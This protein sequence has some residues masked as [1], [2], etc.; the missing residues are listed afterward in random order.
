M[1]KKACESPRREPRPRPTHC[2][3]ET[4]PA[5]GTGLRA[6]GPICDGEELDYALSPEGLHEAL[7][8][9]QRGTM[10]KASVSAWSLDGW[11]RCVRLS[12]SLLDGTY[13]PAPPRHFTVTN[14]K[15]RE[16]VSIG[17]RDRVYQRSL[18][19][20]AVYPVMTR[21]LVRE[22]CACQEGKGTDFARDLLERDIRRWWLHHGLDG[23]VM[24]LDIHGYYDHLRHDVALGPFRRRLGP[25]TY[26]RVEE[27][28]TTQ[29]AGD[30]GF[31]P[32]SQL[33][34]LVGICTLDPLDH[35][36]KEG[37]G[38]RDYVRYMDDMVLLGDRRQLEAWRA[39]VSRW[40]GER[41]LE[42]NE[43]KTRFMPLGQRIPFLGLTFQLTE[44]GRVIRRMRPEKVREERR[45]LARMVA[46]ARRGELPRETCD[47][48]AA[49]WIGYARIECTGVGCAL[50]MERY[51]DGLWRI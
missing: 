9:C 10:W 7:L 47:M 49:S 29:Y 33:V 16:I 22:N 51:Y 28:L 30:V 17:I 20:N 39:E 35:L 6:M 26:R 46:R 43:R 34:Q 25:E 36:I 27:I 4:S 48:A 31:A 32:G 13:H 50:Q 5:D 41:G 1:V 2:A 38:V 3:G 37:L 18:V 21:S 15:R 14:P 40:L 19:D 11:E 45:R 12:R 42:L 8:A 24:E 23:A 44:S